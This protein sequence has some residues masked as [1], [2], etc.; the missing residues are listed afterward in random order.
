MQAIPVNS[1]VPK[2]CNEPEQFAAANCSER[3]SVAAKSAQNNHFS[4]SL[5]HARFGFLVKKIFFGD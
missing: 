1:G 4:L 2:E 5:G 3:Q